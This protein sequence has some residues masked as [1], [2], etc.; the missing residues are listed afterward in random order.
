MPIEFAKIHHEILIYFINNKEVAF[1]NL[2][3]QTFCI[4]KEN[5]GFIF[6]FQQRI[7]IDILYNQEYGACKF[8]EKN[9]KM[10]L[11]II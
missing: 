8:F 11:I 5:T 1:K 10:D 2:N 6:L 3:N 4:G 9:S 7:K